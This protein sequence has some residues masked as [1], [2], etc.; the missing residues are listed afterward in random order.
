MVEGGR[1]K[2]TNLISHT[3][4]L[5]LHT[6][7]FL[8]QYPGQKHFTKKPEVPS[9][10]PTH[11][12]R[13]EEGS[14]SQGDQ[15]SITRKSIQCQCWP[16]LTHSLFLSNDRA[17]VLS[18]KDRCAVAASCSRRSWSSRPSQHWLGVIDRPQGNWPALTY[19]L[20]RPNQMFK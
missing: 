12:L 11:Q 20:A 17:Y 2:Q 3:S 7:L 19:L 5:L 8:S 1:Q 15:F 9:N 13:K 18:A 16:S 6:P 4:A 14:R 10:A